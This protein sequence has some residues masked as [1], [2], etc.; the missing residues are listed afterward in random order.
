MRYDGGVVAEGVWSGG[1]ID[2]E[3]D[4]GGSGSMSHGGTWGGGGGG[5]SL[6]GGSTGHASLGGL[7]R[8]GSLPGAP[9]RRGGGG[10]SASVH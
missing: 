3:R 2:G 4:A 7:D 5:A 8:L 9:R 10:G 6:G 1:L